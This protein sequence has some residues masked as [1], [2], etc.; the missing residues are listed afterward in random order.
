VEGYAADNQ[1]GE[2]GG[3]TALGYIDPSELLKRL[4]WLDWAN[5]A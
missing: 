1:G 3:D 2:N 5:P 4:Q